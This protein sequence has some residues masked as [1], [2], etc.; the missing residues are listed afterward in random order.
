MPDLRSHTSDARSRR[1][2]SRIRT[3]TIATYTH[4]SEVSSSTRT[5]AVT[6]T[7]TRLTRPNHRKYR[8]LEI[9]AGPHVTAM[10]SSPFRASFGVWVV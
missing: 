9:S 2:C 10:Y 1:K 7:P 8:R 5:T 4:H 3:L 6:I